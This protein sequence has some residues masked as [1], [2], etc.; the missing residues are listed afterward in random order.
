MNMYEK[1]WKLR[2]SQTHSLHKHK[3]KRAADMHPRIKT[4]A[5]LPESPDQ[6]W[7]DGSRAEQTQPQGLDRAQ[8]TEAGH[9]G[10]LT[11]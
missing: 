8:N 10:Y 5:G 1:Q 2:A 4:G 3:H 7:R 11:V 6:Q 9:Q